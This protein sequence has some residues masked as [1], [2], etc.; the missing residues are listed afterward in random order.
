MAQ[1]TI[2]VDKT[3]PKATVA[4]LGAIPGVTISQNSRHNRL[5]INGRSTPLAIVSGG[6]RP[7]AQAT[8]PVL[9]ALAGDKKLGFVVADRLPEHV[10]R[11][12]EKGGCAYADA[13]G[14]VHIE[15]PGVLI[16]VEGRPS[17]RQ[18]QAAAPRGIGVVG[19]RAIQTLLAE[20]ERAWSAVDLGNS[21]ACSVGNAH[22]VLRRLEDEGLL[23]TQGRAR[24]LRRRA[25][26]PGELLDWLSTVPAARRIRE[27]LHA[28]IYAGDPD[29]LTTVVSKYALDAKLVYA[30]TAAAAARIWGAGTTTAIPVTMLRIHPDV[31]LVEA[32]E[33]LH[34]EPVDRGANVVLVRD[35]GEL[36]VHKRARNGP[37]A[38]ALPVRVWLDMLGEPRGEDAAALFRESAI[39]W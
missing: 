33:M 12:L 31:A 28:Y 39:G 30:F 15:V 18:N 32:S 10:R 29:K 38:M 35:F 6:L 11:E 34:A 4:I 9:A 37:A 36:G 20:P 1:V 5:R 24:T 3:V 21:A 7:L 16:H 23:T 2:E 25:T 27:R 26:N 22:N 13:T 14:A 17:R 19:V 8:A